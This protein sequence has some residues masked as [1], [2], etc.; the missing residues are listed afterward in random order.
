MEDD[1]GIL[2]MVVKNKM[3]I[4]E[5]L[6]VCVLEEVFVLKVFKEVMLVDFYKVNEKVM[7]LE[8]QKVDLIFGLKEIEKKVL[9]LE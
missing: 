4:L 8:W 9:S 2:I 7:E 5:E 6:F 1:E 3:V